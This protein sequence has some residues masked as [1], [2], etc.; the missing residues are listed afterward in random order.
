MLHGLTRRSLLRV[1]SGVA[2]APAIIGRAQAAPLELKLSTSQSND[3]KYSSGRVYYD[4][5]V[6]RLAENNLD[7]AIKIQFFP[8]NQLGQEI[9]VANSLKLG[10]IDLMSTGTPI[11]ANLIPTLGVMDLGYLFH[12]FP[13]QTKAL[14]AGV[15]AKLAQLALTR[16]NTRI[17]G[18]AYDFGPRCILS[19]TP[20]TGPSEIANKKI[21]T[22]PNPVVTECLR[23]MGAA[24]TPMAFG[25]VY[26]ALQAG[27]LDGLE[28]NA[29][30]IVASKLYETAKYFCPTQHIFTSCCC[31]LSDTTY[32]QLPENTREPFLD[33]CAKAAVDARARALAADVEALE[34][35]KQHGV[36]VTECD[37][38]AFRRR[39]LPQTDAFVKAHPEAKELVDIIR[40]TEA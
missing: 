34:T 29:S 6:K 14:E 26:T 3:V 31:W 25:E 33:A 20:I 12:S 32:N 19:K 38:E 24:A 36:T 23:L 2:V 27:V 13:Q 40:S 37:T 30:T 21:R 9:D 22:L 28:H 8:D 5:L 16:A 7:Q 39:V 15:A 1:A 10:A 11:W 35:L 18:W 17:V 4:F